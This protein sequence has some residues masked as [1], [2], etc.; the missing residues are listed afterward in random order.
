MIK[1]QLFLMLTAVLM[2][3]FTST[4]WADANVAKVTT[5][6]TDVFFTDFSDARAAWA[7][8]T[9]L[10]LLADITIS[11][12][13]HFTNGSRT[14]DLNG[15]GI[16]YMGTQGMFCIANGACITLNDSDPT[17]THK[18]SVD[19]NGFATLDEASGTVTINGGYITGGIGSNTYTRTTSY[20]DGGAFFIY[21]GSTVT[22]NGGTLIG[23]GEAAND[24]TG[25]AV[26]IA[27]NG[28]FILNG[29]TIT[30]NRAKY[31]GG[32]SLYGGRLT[33]DIAEQAPSTLEIHGGEISYNYATGNSG[34]VHTNA[35]SCAE[36]VTITGGSIINNH[37]PNGV[38]A[39]GL[40]V[41]HANTTVYL[42]GNPTI[43][44]NLSGTAQKNI[45]LQSTYVLHIN[46]EL[47]N[48]E[49]IGITRGAGAGIFT[50][51]LSG[52]GD[53]S[54]FSSDNASYSV[55][56]HSNGE[57][58]LCTPSSC[59]APT[60]IDGLV[61]NG[62]AQAL[63]NAGTVNGGTMLY[64]LDNSTWDAAIPTGTAAGDYTVYYMVQGDAT[65]ADYTPADNTVAVSIAINYLDADFAIDFRTDPYTVVGGGSLPTGVAVEGS[66]NPG[67]AQHGYR[68]P[69]ITIPVKAG[70]YKVTMG[71]CSYSHQDGV[72]KNED[73][74]E[75]FATLE[76]NNATC[77]HQNT[78][79]N[80]VAKIF[81]VPSDQIIKV[82]GAEYT[83][84]FAIEK[85]AAVPAF[86]DFEINFMSDPYSV[87]GTLPT[88]T[89]IEG[90]WHGDAHGFTNVVATVPVEAGS[91]RLTLGAC[92]YGNGAGNVMDETNVEL[93]SFNQKLAEN[94]KCYHQNPTE[95]IVST[96]FTVDIDQT[97][98]IDCGQYTPYM[99]LEKISA[100][101]VVFALGDAEGTAPAA[102]DVTIGDALTMPVNRTMYKGGYTL[103]GWSDGVNT[104][105]IGDSFTPASD[106]VLN[107]VFTANAADAL[108]GKTVRWYFGTQNGAPEMHLEG[109]SGNGFLIA[110]ADP[111]G[112]PVD[113]KLYIDATSGK[114]KNTEL[115]D[116]RWAQ[117]N[118]GT[119]LTFFSEDGAVVKVWAMNEPAESMLDGNT[120]SAWESNIA[121]YTASP[122]AGVSTY[123][124]IG[125]ATWYGYLEVT[126]PTS[127]VN[128]TAKEDPNH[129]G[130]YYATFFDSAKKYALPND[131]TEAYAAEVSGDAMYLHKIAEGNDVLPANTAVIFKA[132]SNTITLT[133]SD[134]APVAI[135]ATNHL[136]GVDVE[137]TISDVVLGTCYVLSGG[138]NGV[139]FYL[140]QAPNVLKAHKAYIDLDGSGAAQAPKH[141]R[142]IFESA[143]G[144]ENVHGEQ[145]STKVVENGVLYIIKSGV[146]YNAQGQIVK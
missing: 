117:V 133:P 109:G 20:H 9:T 16:R 120:K 99:K 45:Q 70:N 15:H 48:T 82:Y 100:Y 18:F 138:S 6:G 37:V 50:T 10:T 144:V 8:G 17:T 42:S 39:A 53:A 72:V 2:M 90:T 1:K 66:M 13:F 46:G 26:F 93:A 134:D 105:A 75:T 23:N 60:A 136:H 21:N 101:H 132:P 86:S 49:P 115:S 121:T 59:T 3:G 30:R 108:Q 104:Y 114:F 64:S 31:G 94:T 56:L 111:T 80:V 58:K 40:F 140:Y 11:D 34:G 24:R 142:F 95:N 84:Y 112:T 76:V 33:A 27:R 41:E 107:P 65:H 22:M 102:V 71:T 43:K 130:V 44:D 97:I 36:T 28:H 62:S 32:I 5:S 55:A 29:G 122:A 79:T 81:N 35:Y 106:V 54:K 4:A 77:Y 146:K 7:D 68:L 116:S 113:V 129:A 110:Q 123:A 52:N 51:G 47:T 63:V 118:A 128:V 145:T 19:E 143:Q 14:L 89:G 87:S 61:A 137:T 96:T 139:G 67:D 88:G 78:A 38:N 135:S 74:S 141:L 124:V 119:V 69:V 73:G 12:Y 125:N 126:Y 103:T 98:T 83:P 25:G 127:E 92:G 91:Y 85:M 131:G 57:A